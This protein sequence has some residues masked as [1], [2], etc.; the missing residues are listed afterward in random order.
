MQQLNGQLGEFAYKLCYTTSFDEAFSLFQQHMQQLGF[1]HMLYTFIPRISLD[2]PNKHQPKLM[3]SESYKQYLNYYQ[4]ANLAQNDYTIKLIDQGSKR[5]LDWW[6]DIRNK[7][8]T[9]A[10]KEVVEVARHDYHMK[11]GLTIPTLVGEKGIAG[12]SL[13]SMDDDRFFQTL[14]EESMT[15]ALTSTALFH[16]HTMA[17]SFEFSPFIQ[18]LIDN[19]N[20]TEK[21]IVN[22]LPKGLPV[23][24]IAADVGRSTG[25]TEKVIRNLRIKMGGETPE[26]KPRISTRLL[27][28]YIGLMN[29]SEY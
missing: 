29:L 1:D 27:T 21:K 9:P 4:E 26:H 8:L 3:V 18:P 10:E 2:N 19:L 14:K 20:E 24:H 17:N 15:L 13:I 7:L 5:P 25:Y 12:A 16:N 6:E 22:C 11:N 23:N 28:Y